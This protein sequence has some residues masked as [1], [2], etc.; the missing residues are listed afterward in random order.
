MSNTKR[1]RYLEEEFGLKFQNICILDLLR[2]KL[3]HFQM[4]A[5]SWL[6]ENLRLDTSS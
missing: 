1:W 6:D 3:K 5:A 4:E 2:V